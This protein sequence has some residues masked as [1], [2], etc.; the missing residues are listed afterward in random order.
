MSLTAS[1]ATSLFTI[2]TDDSDDGDEWHW[3]DQATAYRD[4]YTQFVI[5]FALGLGAFVSFCVC[6]YFHLIKWRLLLT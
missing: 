4:L 6:L 1:A 3:G 5:S 2:F